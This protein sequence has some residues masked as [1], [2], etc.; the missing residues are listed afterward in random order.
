MKKLIRSISILSFLLFSFS[1]FSYAGNSIN[2]YEKEYKINGI[3]GIN[4]T[5]ACEIYIT[6]SEQESL[7]I[8]AEKDIFDKIEVNQKDSTLYIKTD[9]DDYDFD[10]WDIEVYLS[11]KDLQS[12]DIGGAVKLENRGTLKTNKLSIEISGAA[13]IELS[14]EVK[15]LL[16][17]FSGAVNAELEG[18][19]DYVVMDMSG[20]SKVDA[21][22]LVTRAYY[23]DFSGF[24][25][26]D[27]YAEKMLKIDMSGM[28]VVRYSGNPTKIETE[29]SGLGVIK[30]R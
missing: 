2:D 30:S 24:G 18:K 4:L 17:D 6:Q 5:I 12:I 14:L 1:G 11:V 10:D 15:K 26:A 13:D 25:K 22:D 9:E 16:A 27:V 3:N 19:A 7:K 29:S 23:L 20:A 21:N 28:G 8:E